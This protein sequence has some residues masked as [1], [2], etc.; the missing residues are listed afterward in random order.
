MRMEVNMSATIVITS[1]AN[2]ISID[3]SVVW[4]GSD[5][6]YLDRGTSTNRYPGGFVKTLSR[7]KCRDASFTLDVTING[8][9]F[10][11]EGVFGENSFKRTFSEISNYQVLYLS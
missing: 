6:T 9:P 7:G 1:S 3:S 5:S 4:T 2:P 11:V 8:A 10:N